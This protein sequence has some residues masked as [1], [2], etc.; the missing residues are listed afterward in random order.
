LPCDRSPPPVSPPPVSPPPVSPP[1]V[2]PPP[3]DVALAVCKITLSLATTLSVPW[4]TVFGINAI[5]AKLD[6]RSAAITKV[7]I[8]NGSF[9]LTIDISQ[10][11]L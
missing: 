10:S 5:E 11:K 4:I 9:L 8:K 6:I 1:P 3:S 2:S 7:E